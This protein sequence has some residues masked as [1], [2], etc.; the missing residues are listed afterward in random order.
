LLQDPELKDQPKGK[1]NWC[2]DYWRHRNGLEV[3]NSS[4]D[5]WIGVES[6]SKLSDTGF[7]PKYIR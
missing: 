7:S 6:Q 4:D 1:L 5:L 2:K 3:K